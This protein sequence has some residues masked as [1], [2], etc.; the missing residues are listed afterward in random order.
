MQQVRGGM[1]AD[2][3]FA[4]VGKPAL[5]GFGLRLLKREADAK[6]TAALPAAPVTPLTSPTTSTP[7]ARRTAMTAADEKRRRI[8]NIRLSQG[9]PTIERRKFFER[10]L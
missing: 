1:I 7:N 8:P 5:G 9:S 4:V 10:A 6:P 2:A 3:L